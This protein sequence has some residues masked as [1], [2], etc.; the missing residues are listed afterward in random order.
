MEVEFGDVIASSNTDAYSGPRPSAPARYEVPVG[1]NVVDIVTMSDDENTAGA[2]PTEQ[3]LMLEY[4][5][6]GLVAVA[7]AGWA[8]AA[9][10]SIAM[11]SAS[12]TLNNP[13]RLL[14]TRRD[15]PLPVI[16]RT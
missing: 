5:V 2:N 9:V 3:E 6:A 8:T 14:R 15:I 11:I 7:V 13:D 4:T 10:T 12:G 16:G 1:E